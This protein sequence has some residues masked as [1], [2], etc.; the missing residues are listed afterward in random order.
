MTSKEYDQTIQRHYDQVAQECGLS[1]ASTMAD[2]TIRLLETRAVLAFADHVGRELWSAAIHDELPTGARRG[3]HGALFLEVGCGNGY[4]LKRLAQHLP[5]FHFTGMEPNAE[6]RALAEQQVQGMRNARVMSGDLRQVDSI[7][8]PGGPVDALVCQRVLINLLDRQDQQQALRNIA[9][10]VR[11]QGFLFFIE[12]FEQGL[13][14]LNAARQEFGLSPIPPAMHNLYLPDGFFDI[15]ELAP[16]AVAGIT[17]HQV[18]THYYVSRVLHDVL[19]RSAGI[20][21]A[22]RNSHFVRFFSAAL[23][24]SVGDYAPLRMVCFRRTS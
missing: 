19:L 14:N 20:D 4:T 6:L 10:L 2:E 3:K 11:P 12:A 22:P 17:C 9:R 8:L 15:P 1:P 21:D 13:V 16:I 7:D 24:D 5:M 18:S 23:K